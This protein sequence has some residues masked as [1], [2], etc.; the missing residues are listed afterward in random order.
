MLKVREAENEKVS[1]DLLKFDIP[2]GLSKGNVSEE[3][4]SEEMV[5]IRSH[6]K[7]GT[8]W[9]AMRRI[10]KGSEEIRSQI[11]DAGML[12]MLI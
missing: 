8:G 1:V 9:R 12:L 4:S 5:Q 3:V 6:R 2:V 11:R 10:W 7:G